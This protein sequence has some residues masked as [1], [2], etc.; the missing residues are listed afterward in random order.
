M[1]VKVGT[2]VVLKNLKDKETFILIH[3]YEN[4]FVEIRKENANFEVKLVEKCD[5]IKIEI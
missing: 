3:D 5:L 1:F 2:K 4:G